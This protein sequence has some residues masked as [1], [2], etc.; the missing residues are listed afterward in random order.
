MKTTDQIAAAAASTVLASVT[1]RETLDGED[2]LTALGFA[3]G[4]GIEY[5]A[6]LR[7]IVAAAITLDREQHGHGDHGI[8]TTFYTGLDGTPVVQ[9]DTTEASGLVRVNLNDSTIYNGNPEQH[10]APGIPVELP[11]NDEPRTGDPALRSALALVGDDQRQGWDM[12]DREAAEHAR[13]TLLMPGAPSTP[14]GH[15]LDGDESD[16]TFRA[17]LAV[18]SASSAEI[19]AALNAAESPATAPESDD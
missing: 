1:D 3:M 16:A 19:A 4:A 11:E 13:N 7:Q 2:P 5:E 15:Y 10:E 18:L 9:I 14:G 12:S 6:A 17:Y 8:E